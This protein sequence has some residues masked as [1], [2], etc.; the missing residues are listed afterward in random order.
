MLSVL[1][2]LIDE[3]VRFA[4]IQT[5]PWINVHFCWIISCRNILGSSVGPKPLQDG[6]KLDVVRYW[7]LCVYPGCFIVRLPTTRAM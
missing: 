7:W 2:Y 3:I 6:H 1:H 4:Q 5:D